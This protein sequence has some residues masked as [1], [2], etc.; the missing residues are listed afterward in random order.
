MNVRARNAVELENELNFSPLHQLEL[1]M[2]LSNG[3]NIIAKKLDKSQMISNKT[4]SSHTI[5]HNNSNNNLNNNN[6]NNNNI[7]NNKN[8][9]NHN[10]NNPD[11][12]SIYSFDLVSTNGRLLDRLDFEND[13]YDEENINT[14]STRLID[15]LSLEDDTNNYNNRGMISRSS[16][17]LRQKLKL[18]SS[19]SLLLLGSLSRKK[20]SR[21]YIPITTTSVNRTPS[22]RNITISNP[23]PQGTTPPKETED[24]EYSI[25]NVESRIVH[26]ETNHDAKSIF[27]FQADMASLESVATISQKIPT[28]L[29]L[30]MNKMAIDYKRDTIDGGIGSDE[31]DDYNFSDSSK[32]KSNYNSPTIPFNKLLHK[33]TNS[34][35]EPNLEHLPKNH[36]QPS[37]LQQS[38]EE[39]DDFQFVSSDSGSP[40]LAI[41]QTRSSPVSSVKSNN[42]QTQV[43]N[44]NLAYSPPPQ[45]P[46]GPSRRIVS[47]PIVRTITSSS[48]TSSINSSSLSPT[49][50]PK[51]DLSPSARTALA[52]QLRNNGNHREALY[53]LQLAANL[54]NNYPKAMYLYAMA[55][56]YG[57]GVKLNEKNSI[58][59][60]LRCLLVVHEENTTNSSTSIN[61]YVS[62]LVALTPEDLVLIMNNYLQKEDEIDPI[63]LF[64]YY[65]KLPT[66]QLSKL[67]ASVKSLLNIVAS[68]YHE[69]GNCLINS[70][71]LQ[72]SDELMGILY[73]SKSASMGNV[74][75]MSQLGKFGVQNRKHIKR[76]TLKL[77]L[78]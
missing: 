1:Q 57:Q 60:L 27:S 37:H 8:N 2:A 12:D 77:Q 10:H 15:K 67:I 45:P 63:A 18:L 69:V 36:Y 53:Q 61:E 3:S 54:P 42:S 74:A 22:A 34:L 59:W 32:G 73:L 47:E 35:P 52:I 70:W 9:N 68:T 7:N 64:D 4:S 29:S 25:G 65:S 16:S 66:G 58:K 20:S 23:Y 48:S 5:P 40:D 72:K 11:R 21:K 50:F 28:P 78:G 56:R 75:S 19:L 46:L 44:F 13:D 62:K 24:S 49:K 6:N 26:S 76:I 17:Q 41:Q 31:D 33:R 71:G 30:P 55:L 43:Q 51:E 39:F 38:I 14:Q